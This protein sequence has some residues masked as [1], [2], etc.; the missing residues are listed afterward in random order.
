MATRGAKPTPTALKILNG[1]RKDRIP[2][3]EPTPQPGRPQPSE[4]LT[5]PA[6][7]E[8]NRITAALEGMR[9]LTTADA[10]ALTLYALTYADAHRAARD[11]AKQGGVIVSVTGGIKLNPNWTIL[12]QARALMLR[13]LTEYGLTASSRSRVAAPS[14]APADPLE[15][16]LAGG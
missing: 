11:L 10:A 5:G 3:N 12:T 6:L 9:I 14:A 15:A 8:W 16:F 7:A 2:K 4:E 1:T 13:I